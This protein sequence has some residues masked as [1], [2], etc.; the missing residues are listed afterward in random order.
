MISGRTIA[1]GA[2]V[3]MAAT[4]L[5]RM[6]GFIRDMVIANYFGAT[7]ATDAY[8]ATYPVLIG[9]GL[10]IAASVSAGFIPV[11]NSYLVSGDREN[12][13]KVVNTLLNLLFFLLLIVTMI[14]TFSVPV[15][16]LVKIFAPG[17]KGESVQLTGQLIRIM[18]PSLIFVSLMGIA[19]GF[20][21]SRQHFLF[22]A[23]GPIFTS[24]SIIGSIVFL[25]PSLGVKRLA[26]GTFVGFGLQF[27]IQLPAMYKKGFR[28]KLELAV[29]HPGVVRVFKLM[30][31]V[32]A[33]S[34]APPLILLVERRLASGLDTG[35][36]S[37]LTYAFRLMQL[38]QGLFVMAVSI[39][40][41]PA[42][43]A[44]AAQKDFKKLKETLA[45]GMGVLAVIM[46]PASAGLIALAVPIVRLLFE[47]GAFE[48]KDTLPTAYALV[49]YSLALGPL[50]LRDIFRRGFYSLQDT[51]TTVVVTLLSFLVNVVLDL[52]LVE[53]MGIG[54]LALGASLSVLIEVSLLYYLFSR[55]MKGLTFKSFGINLIKIIIASIVMGVVAYYTS[56][57]LGGMMN[58][59]SNFARLLQVGVSICL[60]L[61]VYVVAVIILKVEVVQD[62]F[63]MIK[64]VFRKFAK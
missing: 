47:R 24:L 52:A 11:F 25:D 62:A 23:L 34:M 41:F 50:A 44:L 22:P 6:F 63:Q 8:Q 21:N 48:A 2:A 46:I 31:P 30:L 18:L 56:T 59:G 29:L 15:P 32:L 16:D 9:I 26:I 61:I 58:L 33:A 19:S 57:F 37:T 28:Y 49:F 40:L 55:K 3:V 42:L 12:A 7:G 20:L 43:S 39:P 14:G 51:F 13:L 10:A 60:G 53:V 35:S 38:P 64:D 17:F 4:L 45:K 27:L 1:K 5:S 54:G 36:I